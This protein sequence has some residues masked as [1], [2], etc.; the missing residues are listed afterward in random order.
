[1][2][3]VNN[4][5]FEALYEAIGAKD[6]RFAL[7]AIVGL[8][9][10]TDDKMDFISAFSAA[11]SFDESTENH[12]RWD[13]V[14]KRNTKKQAT[15]EARDERV[16]KWVKENVTVGMMLRFG[17]TRDLKGFRKV[18]SIRE[19]KNVGTH[20]ECQK[21]L[22]RS[23]IAKAIHDNESYKSSYWEEQPIITEHMA[24]KVVHVFWDGKWQ[25]VVNL[26]KEK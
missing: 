25:K 1:M 22:P 26:C 18:R 21:W 19:V 7:E 8:E 14:E 13:A 11:K 23:F 12:A 4:P 20:L 17:G 10:E 15:K 3:T 6:A 2:Y 9:F 5:I 16:A 24:K